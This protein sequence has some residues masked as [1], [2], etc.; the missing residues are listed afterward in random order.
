MTNKSTTGDEL[1]SLLERCVLQD[2]IAF[3]A[4]YDLTSSRLYATLF[5]ILRIEAV[6]EEALQE[7]YV[8]IWSKASEYNSELGQPITWM[9]SIA[10]YQA[11]DMLRK[12]RIREDR[13]T[14]WDATSLVDRL[15]AQPDPSQMAEYQDVLEKC[16]DRLSQSQRLCIIRAYIEGL[17]HDELSKSTKTPVGTVKSWIRRGLVSLKECINEYT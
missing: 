1:G 16:F 7:T 8:K 6:A 14:D 3:K 15:M 9:T 11:L 12:R 4:L 2:Q 13:E 5:N 17:T 10:R